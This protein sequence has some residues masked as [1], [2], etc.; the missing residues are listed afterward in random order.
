MS[1]QAYIYGLVDPRT[2]EIMYI[3]MST[4]PTQ[5]YR[6]HCAKPKGGDTQKNRW[7][8]ELKLVG[9]KPRMQI[10]EECSFE[11][12][13]IKEIECA[14]NHIMSGRALCQYT[15]NLVQWLKEN[16]EEVPTTIVETPKRLRLVKKEQP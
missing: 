15:G 1:K 12:R 13:F 7:I 3:G 4:N 5:R 14:I 11:E 2:N 8:D 9:M 6:A 10:L 16:G